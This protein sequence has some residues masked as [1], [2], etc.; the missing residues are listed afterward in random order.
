MKHQQLELDLGKIDKAADEREKENLAFI[1]F[2]KFESDLT[3]LEVD[4]EFHKLNET[5]SSRID[6]TQCAN[7]CK[8]LHPEILDEDLP[9]I[10]SHLN[11]SAK[12]FEEHYTNDFQGDRCMQHSPCVFLKD[13]KCSIYEDRP[14]PCATYPNLDAENMISRLRIVISNYG[15]CPIVYNVVETLKEEWEFSKPDKEEN[16]DWA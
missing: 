7:C 6:C 1:N 4:K 10:A 2:I 11:V 12:D 15:T 13:K 8:K 16:E 9:R 14:L 3:N 5:I